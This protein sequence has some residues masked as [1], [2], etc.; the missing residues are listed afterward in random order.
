MKVP[1]KYIASSGDEYD[2]TANGIL[3]RSAN[4]YSWTWGVE[5]TKLQYG[6]RVSNFAREAAEYDAELVFYGEPAALRRTIRALHNDFE[7]DLRSKAPGRII[8]GDYYIDCYVTQSTADPLETWTYISDKIHIYVPYP[9]WMQ[10]FFV[11]LPVSRTT[12][13]GF[14][15]YPYDYM[16]DYTSPAV[17]TRS[18]QSDFPFESE[19]KMVIYGPVVNPRITIN[20]YPYVLYATIPSNA[21][22]VIDSR[23]KSIMM[24]S[25][26][27]KTNMFNFRNKT[28]SIFAKIPGGNLL[29]TW[30]SSFGCD[31]TIFHEKSEPEFEEVL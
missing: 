17:G 10:D 24:Y 23:N 27:T 16:Y 15:D 9:F 26:G 4:Y 8:L 11:S 1:I 7:N 22:V 28:D 6:T 31:I 3:H 25:G 20:N 2:L 13:G 5:G 30:D 19:F 18:I 12:T 29:I 14:L 21:Y